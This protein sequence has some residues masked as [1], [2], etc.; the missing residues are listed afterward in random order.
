MDFRYE[1][2]VKS[3]KGISAASLRYGEHDAER[4]GLDLGNWCAAPKELDSAHLTRR[5]EWF[6]SRVTVLKM[7]RA[8]AVK[9]SLK[10]HAVHGYPELESPSESEG[11]LQVSWAHTRGFVVAALCSETVGVDTEPLDRPMGSVSLRIANAQERLLVENL[12]V[13]G[14]PVSSALALWCAKEAAAKASG[15]GMRWGLKNFELRPPTDGVWP[16]IIHQ[17]GPRA[18]RD[19]AVRFS[20]QEEFLVAVCAERALLLAPLTFN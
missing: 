4:L 6:A 18:L 19:P 9:A 2:A 16:L 14:V 1:G 20:V 5:S 8:R 7:L 15:L 3:I 13:D 11:P 12:F 10:M 17:P